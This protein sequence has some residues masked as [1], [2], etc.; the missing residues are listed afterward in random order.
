MFLFNMY[1]NIIRIIEMENASIILEMLTRIQILEKQ[2]AELK[3]IIINQQKMS[4]EFL[5]KRDSD[6]NIS[7]KFMSVKDVQIRKRDT[8]K[9]LFNDKVYKK[10][11][12][13]LAVVKEYASNHNPSFDELAKVFHSSLQGSIGVVERVN[14]AQ[15]RQDYS[16]RFFIEENDIITLSDGFAYVCNQWGILNIPRFL[17]KAKDLGYKIQEI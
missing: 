16:V 7:E 3:Q 2:V 8:T 13:V 11:R 6:V 9:Y 12:L 1:N 5:P 10:N 4:T 15:K 17:C 14:V